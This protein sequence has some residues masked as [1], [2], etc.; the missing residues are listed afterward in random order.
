VGWLRELVVLALYTGMH[1]GRSSPS[2]GP[3]MAHATQEALV[4]KK[5][6]IALAPEL[7]ARMRTAVMRTPG[8]TLATLTALALD[9]MVRTLERQRWRRLYAVRG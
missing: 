6:T 7:I 5:V 1:M 4:M 3:A 2:R 8:L 9:R